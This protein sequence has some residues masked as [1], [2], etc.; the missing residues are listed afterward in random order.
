M[1][2]PT[3][4]DDD[5]RVRRAASIELVVLAVLALAGVLVTLTVVLSPIGLLVL[6]LAAAAFRRVRRARNDPTDP[7]ARRV[8]S[9]WAAVVAVVLAL[10]AALVLLNGAWPRSWVDAAIYLQLVAWPA[11]AFW[12]TSELSAE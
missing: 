2:E 4:L 8:A 1:S 12:A 6:V 9:R 11:V 3:V 10:G 7:E 5:R